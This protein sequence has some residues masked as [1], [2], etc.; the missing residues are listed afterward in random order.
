MHSLFSSLVPELWESVMFSTLWLCTSPS[1]KPSY[2]NYFIKNIIFITHSKVS[3]L[4]PSAVTFFNLKRR[5]ERTQPLILTVIFV[6]F[7]Y[8][9]KVKSELNNHAH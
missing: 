4:T 5:A 6:T 7:E 3:K 2:R 8:L 1:R 9:E